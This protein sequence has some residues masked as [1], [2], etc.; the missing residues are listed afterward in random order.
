MCPEAEKQTKYNR[1]THQKV[2]VRVPP[3][4]RKPRR[5]SRLAGFL[6]L[7]PKPF[8]KPLISRIEY[9]YGSVP[10]RPNGTVLKTVVVNSYR[11]F[12]SHRFLH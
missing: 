11:G 10:E 9:R 2:G 1:T 3:S 5:I 6:L 7:T 8:F 12:K 4:A